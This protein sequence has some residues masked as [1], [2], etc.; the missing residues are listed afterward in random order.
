V[1]R[2]AVLDSVVQAAQEIIPAL[3]SEPVDGVDVDQGEPESL[4][5]SV[6]VGFAASL[7][8]F[9]VVQMSEKT[10]L[11]VAGRMLGQDCRELGSMEQSCLSELGNMVM[12]TATGILESDGY[13]LKVAVP[14]V[15]VGRHRLS[16]PGDGKSEVARLAWGGE[17]IWLKVV[18]EEA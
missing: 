4:D 5:V 18:A 11:A 10:A 16:A 6:V 15:V 8:G 12:G 3:T 2:R 13:H 1:D 14:A 17:E 7:R 9:L